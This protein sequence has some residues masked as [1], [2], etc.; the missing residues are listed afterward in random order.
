MFTASPFNELSHGLISSGLLNTQ[1]ESTL[2]LSI[3]NKNGGPLAFRPPIVIYFSKK[4]VSIRTKNLKEKIYIYILY[5]Y[6][7][8]RT[9]LERKDTVVLV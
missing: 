4:T 1:E 3:G 2:T 5:T 7:S 6:A 8:N 9:V